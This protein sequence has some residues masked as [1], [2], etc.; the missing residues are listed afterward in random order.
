[1]RR[2][3]VAYFRTEVWCR[4]DEP[5]RLWFS[6]APGTRERPEDRSR[7]GEQLQEQ[8]GRWGHCLL[9]QPRERTLSNGF[10][11]G[12]GVDGELPGVKVDRAHCQG[13]RRQ[14][15][16]GGGGREPGAPRKTSTLG[17][18][19]MLRAAQHVG[20]F[21]LGVCFAVRPGGHFCTRRLVGASRLR[22][23]LHLP[24]QRDHAGNH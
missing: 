20:T 7:K 18:A 14:W 11:P 8:P 4:S 23:R 5:K 3:R 2:R 22:S 16:G 19:A 6:T 21:L 13:S 9:L 15:A 10:S 17:A 12:L 1:M 24:H